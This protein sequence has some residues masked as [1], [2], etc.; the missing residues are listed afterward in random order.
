[1][2]C[3][4]LLYVSL[5]LLNIFISHF[6]WENYFFNNTRCCI[7][8]KFWFNNFFFDFKSSQL[9][10]FFSCFMYYSFGVSFCII[11]TCFSNSDN[12]FFTYLL[13]TFLAI[14]ENLNFFTYFLVLGSVEYIIPIC[15]W[16]ISNWLCLLFLMVGYFYQ[17]IL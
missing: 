14:D 5:K 16:E 11:Q 4:V 8:Y 7:R 15:E 3:T 9:S 6:W 10:C 1:M 13:D 17:W 2:S 12:Y